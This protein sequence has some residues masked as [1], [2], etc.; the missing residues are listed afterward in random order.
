MI[1]ADMLIK[2][3]AI[4]VHTTDSLEFIKVSRKQARL[5]SS[6]GLCYRKVFSQYSSCG[7]SKDSNQSVL[8]G[9]QIGLLYALQ[10]SQGSK[11]FCRC[12]TL[13]YKTL[14]VY[15]DS[16]NHFPRSQLGWRTNWSAQ[17]KSHNHF[18][19][20]KLG[21]LSCT[22]W[23]RSNMLNVTMWGENSLNLP[24]S[25]KILMSHRIFKPVPILGR[26]HAYAYNML[27]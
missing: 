18:W 21:C 3:E 23:P 17:N 10:N 7:E 26:N 1:K 4:N 15:Y 13:S 6:T 16:F 24:L 11:F 5:W 12:L 14:Q 2:R 22:I 20:E 25:R 19:A 9:S 27:I 8:P